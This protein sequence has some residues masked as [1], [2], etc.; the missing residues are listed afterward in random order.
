MDTTLP[1]LR[2]ALFRILHD[3]VE[4]ADVPRPVAVARV[5]PNRPMRAGELHSLAIAFGFAEI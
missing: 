5:S 3:A 2:E 4:A 1:T